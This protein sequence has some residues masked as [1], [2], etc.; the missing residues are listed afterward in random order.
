MK[1]A[2]VSFNHYGGS[3]ERKSGKADG[4]SRRDAGAAVT[5]MQRAKDEPGARRF[6]PLKP[7]PGSLPVRVSRA[8]AIEAARLNANRDPELHNNAEVA[9][10]YHP[11]R[12]YA[13][14]E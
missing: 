1:T 9:T 7:P 6:K 11:P 4:L 13:D 10:S 2:F 5:A 8:G 3:V 12:G 14:D